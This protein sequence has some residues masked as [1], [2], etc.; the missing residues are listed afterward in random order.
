[1][2]PG[3]TGA[4]VILAS[5][6]AVQAPADELAP[7]P[8]STPAVNEALT[9]AAIQAGAD[10]TAAEFPAPP[11]A[12]EVIYVT[13][14]RIV[15][16][17]RQ[18]VSPVQSVRSE[19]FVMTGVANVEQ[20]LNQ[21]PQLVPSFTNTSNNPGTGAATLD[22]RGL[23]SVRTLILVNGRRWIANDAGEIPEIDVNTIPAA[24][25]ERVDIVTGG[26]S[27]VYGSDAVS[28]VINFVL[29]D[30]LKG[31]E[32]E[33][34]QN[35]T[36][37]G[38]SRV[39]SVDLAFGTDFV[40]GRGRLL[41][42]LGWLNQDPTFQGAR[43]FGAF[44][45]Q[46]GCI[47]A[48]S[49]DEFGAG[50]GTGSLTC[51]ADNEEWGYIRAGSGIIPQTRYQGAQ[52]G[53]I[54][55][56][57]GV[58]SALART[59]PI[60]FAP[61]GDIVRYFAPTD[62]YNYA[63]TNYL[64]VALERTAANLLASYEA[65][66]AFEPFVE[67]SYIRT[68]SP[69]Q[70]APAPGIFGTGSDSVFPARINLDNPFLSPEARQA[71]E[72]TYGRDSANRRGFIGNNAVGFTLN[73]AFTGDADGFV[74]PGFISSRLEGLGP[75]QI[76][77][78]RDAY[79]GLFGL[80][81]EIAKGWS[82]EA[83]YS[84]SFVA[85]DTPYYNSASAKRL[86]QAMLARVGPGGEIVCIDPS[87]GCVPINIFG[88]QD[89]S[90]EAAEFLRIDPIEKTRV[91]EQIAELAV[92]GDVLTLPAGELKAV[93]GAG[94]R[95]TAYTFT[96]DDSFED[97][98]TLGFL[99]STGAAGSTRVF[100]LFGEALVP[101]LEGK[102]FAH[103]LSAELG[104]RFSDYDSVGGVWTWKAM[105]NWSP[106]PQLR[107]RAGLQQAI[108]APNVRELYEESTTDV[109]FA[110][111][112]CA[113]FNGFTLTAELVAACARNGGAGLSDD[114][115]STLVTTGGSTDL[116]P[117]TARTLTAGIVAQPLA[118]LH[119]TLD[120][121]DIDIRDAIGVLGGG[122]GYLGAVTGCIYGG[123]DPADILCQAFTRD[124]DGFVA[125][126]RVPSAN[127]ARLRTR[128][129]D[130]QA[131]YGFRLLSGRL[132]L[133]LS[134]TRLL[135]SDVQT[136]ENLGVIK[137]AGSFGNPCG[138]TIQGVA[139]P[140]WKLFNRA[141]YKVG[142]A[143][144]SLRHRYFSSTKDARLAGTAANSQP[145]PTN[146][147]VN[148]AIAQAR[149]YFDSA[150]TFDIASRF[151]LTLG[152]NNLFDTKPSLVGSQQVQAN[153]DPSLYDVLGRRYFATVSAKFQ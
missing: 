98:D 62:S 132:Q 70:L 101:I 152:V 83:Y 3:L 33:A 35:I 38:D 127:L 57:T 142:P 92:K 136:N 23:G 61:G 120:Y 36:E 49:Q 130:W 111:D 125:E 80:R 145:P 30:R 24:L 69:Q 32:L 55:L 64:Q 68:R 134:G 96:P 50:T 6:A 16:P 87:N 103:E 45:A 143:T 39:T 118:G 72:I 40:G 20:T 58:G 73:P 65:S 86:Q 12:D 41:A 139:I 48:G 106:V 94:W 104:L 107:F 4:Y 133:T 99:K 1:M 21:L 9:S 34:R 91:R 117:E 146:I 100:E 124:E 51:D 148:A 112:P 44:A 18:S 129:I 85:H 11:P 60:R 52:P 151:A 89:I 116:K 7:P 128:G 5:A 138:N 150:I 77:N 43:E 97:G 114:E 71:L 119:F 81:G 102:E 137:C 10:E 121:Y 144:F 56:P 93:F 14:S 19:D 126:L 90:P 113:P 13:G 131:S 76:D 28:G 140:K 63:P 22:L 109:G 37:Q 82:Y 46:D 17:N 153:T 110:V 29:K 108:R 123:A 78:R 147:P 27:A 26:A 115:Y 79:R 67:L 53:G 2:L 122:D 88:Q 42:S 66:P 135:A 95:K 75:R 149:H 59:A 15:T 54:L 8:P 25:I 84:R 74:S 141:S 31:F 105:G 47:V